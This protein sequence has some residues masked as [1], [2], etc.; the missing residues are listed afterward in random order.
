MNITK[1][2]KLDATES[3][4]LEWKGEKVNFE[5]KS[6]TLTPQVLQD[7]GEFISYPKAVASIVT[8]WDVTADDAGNKWPLTEEGLAKLPVPFLTAV[9]NKIAESWSGDE[10]KQTASASG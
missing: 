7:V 9:L 6:V 8:E 2:E 3:F 5:A 10:K 1:V 4:T